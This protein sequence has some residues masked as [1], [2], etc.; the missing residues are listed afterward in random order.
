MSLGRRPVFAVA[1]LFF[2]FLA[3]SLSFQLRQV[4]HKQLSVKVINLVL[5]TERKQANRLQ[6]KPHTH[7][8]QCS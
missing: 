5:E 8:I 7:Q 3:D 2:E 6:L 4:I 1:A